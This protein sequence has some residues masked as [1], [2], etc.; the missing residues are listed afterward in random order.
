MLFLYSLSHTSSV[1]GTF[2]VRLLTLGALLPPL[3][4]RCVISSFVLLRHRVVHPTLHLLCERLSV[5]TPE[6]CSLISAVHRFTH[7]EILA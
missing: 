6:M 7:F 5:G 1:V 3:L 4:L 2:P